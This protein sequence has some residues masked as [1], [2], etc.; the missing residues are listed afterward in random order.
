MNSNLLLYARSRALPMTIA[1]LIAAAPATAWLADWTV[2][3][4]DLGPRARLPVVV[5]APMLVSAAIGASLYTHSEELDRTAVRPWWPRRACQLLLLTAVAAALLGLAVPGEARG[6]G[7]YAMTRNVLGAVGV[8]ALAAALI[9]ARLSWLPMLVHTGA[10]YFTAPAEEGGPGAVWAW[11]VQP[12]PQPAAW[13]TA[14][15]LFA[16]GTC[17]YALRG[18]RPEGT[19]SRR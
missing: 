1:V 2:A 5:L 12:G 9:G 4:S 8:S 14:V 10:V 11:S 17:L 6:Y 3:H 19:G 16:A 18:A 7:A 15:A 13:W